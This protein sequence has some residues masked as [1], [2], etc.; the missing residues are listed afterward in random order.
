M[1]MRLLFEGG[2]AEGSGNG[3]AHEMGVSGSSL[4]HDDAPN[5]VVLLDLEMNGFWF[6]Y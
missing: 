3:Q 5:G 4:V 2:V 1:G 6:L